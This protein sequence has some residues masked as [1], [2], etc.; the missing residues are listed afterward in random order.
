MKSIC[1]ENPQ[2]K[3]LLNSKMSFEGECLV[4][5][6]REENDKQKKESDKSMKESDKQKKENNEETEGNEGS[7]EEREKR[8]PILTLERFL[9]PN[10]IEELKVW[11]QFLTFK[12]WLVK[13]CKKRSNTFTSPSH[14]PTRNAHTLLS[15][16]FSKMRQFF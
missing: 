15:Q 4:F 5:H 8:K 9:I 6:G 10:T 14:P 7:N 1:K 2:K 12:I 3:V 13:K 11:T 16:V